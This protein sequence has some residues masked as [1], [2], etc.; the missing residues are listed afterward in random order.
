LLKSLMYQYVSD[1]CITVYFLFL[2]S[3]LYGGNVLLLKEDAPEAILKKWQIRDNR[4]I[5]NY[6]KCDFNNCAVRY[7]TIL[8]IKWLLLK[9]K[10]RMTIEALHKFEAGILKK[11]IPVLHSPEWKHNVTRVLWMRDQNI[12][13]PFLLIRSN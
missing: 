12:F 2:I 6:G 10:T 8:I 1:F 9:R 5:N 7:G 13:L 11:I 4:K 3:K